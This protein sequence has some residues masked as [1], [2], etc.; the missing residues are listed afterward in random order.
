V[1]LRPWLSPGLLLTNGL[2]NHSTLPTPTGS[3]PKGWADRGEP[4]RGFRPPSSSSCGS[5]AWGRRDL[6]PIRPP[7]QN[8]LERR[9]CLPLGLL[10]RG[11]LAEGARRRNRS[12]S[13]S[14]LL[15]PVWSSGRAGAL[16]GG[17]GPRALA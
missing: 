1:A 17:E 5:G 11:R 7:A 15:M 10:G 14:G 16:Q 6:G 12:L 4:G 2:V 8:P 9:Q 13:R 3:Y